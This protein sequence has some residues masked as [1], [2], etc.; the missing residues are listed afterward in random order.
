MASGD[1]VSITDPFDLQRFV[2]AQQDVIGDVRA[3]LARG[4]KTSHWMWFIFPQLRGLGHSSMAH[5]YGISSRAEAE[6]YLA[7][8]TLGPRLIECTRLVN[9]AKDRTAEQIFGG[10]DALKFRSSMTLFDRLSSGEA[11]SPDEFAQALATFFNGQPDP[12]TIER[13]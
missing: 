3:E 10:V 13:L 8:P 5:R 7:H 11:G 12:L 2:A 9:Q 1:F 4:R 6:A